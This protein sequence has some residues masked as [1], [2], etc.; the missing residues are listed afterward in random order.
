MQNVRKQGNTI[1]DNI[2]GEMMRV[3]GTG[4]TDVAM[5]ADMWSSRGFD[6]YMTTT[7]HYLDA[8]WDMQT[9]ILGECRR[10]SKHL[11]VSLC[12]LPYQRGPRR[13]AGL[14]SV[15]TSNVLL[16][17]AFFN[18]VHAICRTGVAHAGMQACLMFKHPMPYLFL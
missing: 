8:K 14:P 12:Q 13:D 7:L 3:H 15:E 4:E 2:K 1:I 5:T 6:R 9:R 18:C 11:L 17:F 10:D 16:L